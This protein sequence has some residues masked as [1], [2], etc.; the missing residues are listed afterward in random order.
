MAVEHISSPPIPQRICPGTGRLYTTQPLLVL[1][2]PSFSAPMSDQLA[3]NQDVLHDVSQCAIVNPTGSILGASN[4]V[5][6]PSLSL[7]FQNWPLYSWRTR[8]RIQT[9]Q[10]IRRQAPSKSTPSLP[11]RYM[12]LWPVITFN[13]LSACGCQAIHRAA[14]ITTATTSHRINTRHNPFPHPFRSPWLYHNQKLST[15]TLP[16]PICF[17]LIWIMAPG[18]MHRPFTAPSTTIRY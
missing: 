2:V 1:I 16:P 11:Y 3:T 6:C 4:M 9:Q 14:L 18:I 8:G 17:H 15:L 10:I 12:T 13:T 7:I 5:G